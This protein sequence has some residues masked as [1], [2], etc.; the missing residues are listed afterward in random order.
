VSALLRRPTPLTVDAPA[1]VLAGQPLQVTVRSGNGLRVH[2][3]T[4]E[5]RRRTTLTHTVRQWGGMAT[6]VAD[7]TDS[8]VARADLDAASG[9]R[10]DVPDREA[11]IAGYLVQQDYT[12]RVRGR[13]ASGGD[14]E[15][16]TAVRV[17]SAAGTPPRVQDGGPHSGAVLAVG[18]LSGRELRPGAVVTGVV[19]ARSG[20]A[21]R[22]V[23]VELVLDELVAARP[24]EPTEEDRSAGTVVAT[25]RS[26]GP[27]ASEP[28]EPLRWPFRLRAPDPLPAP[29]TRTDEYTLRWLLRA[30][31]DRPLRPDVTTTVELEGRT[32]P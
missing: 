26:S 32:A 10:L 22:E 17:V 23:R 1:E 20:I 6:A 16:S 4:A 24:G 13:T 14:G 2:G 18:E 12:V 7:R 25:E 11:T 29:S 31:V 3:G 28:E 19:T 8:V 30:V 27:V 15:G 5:L 9:T 21:A